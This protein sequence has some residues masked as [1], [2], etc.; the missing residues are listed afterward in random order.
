MDA[1]GDF[2]VAW[3]SDGQDGSGSGIYAQRYN[4]AGVAQGA[5][6]RVN[7][8]TTNNQRVPCG[9]D[10][11]RRRL[12]GRLA[13]Q[14]SGRQRLRASTP[15]A[16]TPRGCRRAPSSGSTPSPRAISV[17]PPSRWTPTATSSSPGRATV[18]TA[19]ATASTPSATTPRAWRRARS[20]ASTPS[21]RILRVDPAVAMDAD[22]D[23]VVAWESLRSGR[24]QLRH[25]RP[26]L[27]RRGRGPGRGVPGQHLHHEIPV[28]SLRGDGRRRRL[29]RR[30]GQL[31]SGRQ[32][33]YGVYAQR[34]NAAGVAQGAEFRVNTFTTSSGRF[35][36]VAMDADGDFVV[37]W[38]SYRQ[39]G[40]IDGVYAQ[41]YNA[42][43]VAQGAEFRV[44]TFTTNDQNRPCRGDGRRRR[45][46]RR[47]AEQPPGRQ[48]L[49]H[50]RPAVRPRPGG[51]RVVLPLR[52]GAAPAALHVRPERLGQPRHRRH[53][54]GEPHDRAD[55]PVER[56]FARLR[57]RAPT[58]RP[59][60]TSAPA[61]RSPACCPT[62]TTAPR[63]SP[64]ASPTV[65]ASPLA[66][67]HVFNFFF[68]NGD[69]N[70]DGRVNLA[71]FNI[72]AANFG[73]IAR[74]FHAGRFQLRQHREPR[75][76][77]HPRGP[78]RDGAGECGVAW[79][80]RRMGHAG[81]RPDR[82]YYRPP[83]M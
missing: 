24:Q 2:V 31:E 12:R 17:S 61:R 39:D 62:A 37:A 43:G 46:R 72:L 71:D 29:R 18:R 78:L 4:A 51:H 64:P 59:S 56:S 73:Q 77:Q 16:T 38:H 58:P 65:Q 25:L 11:R 35:P 36:A 22:G 50:L 28:R 40:S 7:T 15:S 74:G 75:G 42:A 44:N 26:A 70:H 19:A 23:F 81:G 48:Q 67:N 83:C 80:R 6:F 27:Q 76:L 13:E 49:W 3:Q 79:G 55:D 52:D 1:D 47:L 53:R 57:Y 20:S 68:L 54:A 8:F 21:P 60:A 82:R 10:G 69:A 66:A 45:L 14:R 33:D 5:E 30:L 41:R 9:R 34:Y 63:S 32:L